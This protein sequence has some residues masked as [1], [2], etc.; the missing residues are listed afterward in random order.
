M[1]ARHLT[2]ISTLALCSA[3]PACKKSDPAT[4]AAASAQASAAAPGAKVPVDGL[5]G[6]SDFEGVIGLSIKSKD[7]NTH[8]DL[9]IKKGQ[10]RCDL[11]ADLAKQAKLTGSAY[12][13]I[14]AAEGKAYAVIDE[15]KTIV[16]VDFKKIG[17][18]AK[19]MAPHHADKADGKGPAETP[20]KLT[21]TGHMDKVAGYSCEDW[22][23]E[24]KDG[25]KATVCMASS[26]ASWL[27]LPS[28]AMPKDAQWAAELLDGSHFPLRFIAFK[29]GVE[30]ARLELS[31]LD[32]KPIAD[33][34][35]QLPAGYQRIDAMQFMQG[36]MGAAAMGMPGGPGMP[37]MPPG[38]KMTPEMEEMMK[39]MQQQHA[40][41]GH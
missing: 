24:T 32:K 5:A 41:A 36:M 33:A 19:A 17:E 13:I 29:G 15:K 28:F 22:Q 23:I 18:Q 14:N 37:G 39:K 10:V 1:N 26:G 2:L 9:Q 30:E 12:A 7:Q 27:K 21:K 6:L 25:Q 31:K 16:E 38:A 8:V 4:S 11:P 3:L 35:F 20:P 34:A 40:K